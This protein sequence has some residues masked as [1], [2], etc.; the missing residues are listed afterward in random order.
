MANGKMLD[1]LRRL[2]R[3]KEIDTNAALGLIMGAMADV[4]ENMEKGK[5]DRQEQSDRIVLLESRFTEVENRLTALEEKI[6]TL[7]GEVES[8]AA[9]IDARAIKELR[10]SI[11]KNP[12]VR[13]G[14][15]IRE[16]K[17]YATTIFIAILIA[18]NLWFISGF[19]RG[20]LEFLKFPESLIKI[21]VP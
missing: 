16:Y 7:V 10:E 13:L 17:F 5:Q 9:S 14:K 20:V 18:S 2:A 8:L 21:L 4:V 19:R 1:E 12:V 15:F 6:E 3:E 11:E